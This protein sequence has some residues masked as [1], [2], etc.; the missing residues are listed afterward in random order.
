MLV[1]ATVFWGVS[2]PVMKALGMVAQRLLPEASSWFVSA[3]A[4]TVRFGAAAFLLLIWNW[5]TLRQ[6]TRLELRQGLG[7]GLFA[8][9]GMLFQMDGLAYTSASTSAF[10]TQSYCLILPGLVAIR[11]RRR[12]SGLILIC[13]IMV[14]LG[15]AV[16]A[17]VDWQTLTLGRGEWETLIGSLIFTGQILWLERPEFSRNHVQHFTLVMFATMALICLPIGL[18]TMHRPGDW[19]AVYSSPVV[20]GLVAVLVLMCSLV[21]FVMMNYWQPK[22]PA[23]EAGLIY[24]AEPVFASLFALFVPAWCSALA[25]LDYANEKV[26]FNLFLGGGL[27]TMANVLVQIKADGTPRADRTATQTPIE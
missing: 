1:L 16:L 22:I 9:A 25:D 8:G 13:S 3:S 4:L 21:S 12:P 2:F 10:L 19:L 24:C 6:M 11:D 7:L 14:V 20:V 26:T 17:K 5:P 18:L 15:V 27:I 23:A